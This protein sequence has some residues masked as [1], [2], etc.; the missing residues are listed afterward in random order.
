M[1]NLI[2]SLVD[3]GS[4]CILFR[5]R[6]DILSMILDICRWSNNDML[7]GGTIGLR[8]LISISSNTIL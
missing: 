6:L 8:N 2:L 3:V 1:R 4:L 5:Q 7:A